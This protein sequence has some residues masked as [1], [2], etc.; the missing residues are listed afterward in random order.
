M[1]NTAS[2][3][4]KRVSALAAIA[5]AMLATTGCT[6]TNQPATTI[7]YSASDGQ[8][9]NLIGE[10]GQQDIQLR[11]IMVIAADET[12]QGR[13][14]GTILNQTE[15]DAT[16]TLAFPT[17]TLTLK[18]PAGQEVRLEDD[19]NQLLL[20]KAGVAPGLLLKDVEVSSTVTPGTETFNVPVLDGTLEEY[21]PYLPTTAASNNR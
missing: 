5:G 13:L 20:D 8:M 11:N 14:L 2:M 18:I 17:E 3:T 7:V 6:Y 21:A 1:K 12:S 10:N 4:L 15:E 19:K 16:V 9:V